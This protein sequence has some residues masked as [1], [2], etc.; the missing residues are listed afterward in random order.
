[1]TDWNRIS[2]EDMENA[3]DDSK[4]LDKLKIHFTKESFIEGKELFQKPEFHMDNAIRSTAYSQIN[5]II[6]PSIYILDNKFIEFDRSMAI[7]GLMFNI[8]SYSNKITFFMETYENVFVKDRNIWKNKYSP[9]LEIS[10]EN[11]IGFQFEE[12]KTFKAVKPK[13]TLSF[14]NNNKGALGILSRGLIPSLIVT[15][16]LKAVEK[17]EDD[18]VEKT[19]S[20]FRLI[21]KYQNKEIEIKIA[22]EQHYKEDFE[23]FLK[24]QWTTDIPVIKKGPT[25]I[26]EIRRRYGETFEV[27]NKVSISRF[28]GSDLGYVFR[29]ELDYAVIKTFANDGSQKIENVE[30]HKLKKIT[31]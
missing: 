2:K 3:S 4:N 12:N 18:T 27:G 6:L 9:F 5:G 25:T 29:K 8:F 28:F 20:I 31:N 17:S 10:R 23:M 7:F 13:N 22:C 1:M 21:C 19:G 26:K 15:G 30:Y 14:I 24:E 11:I 16:I